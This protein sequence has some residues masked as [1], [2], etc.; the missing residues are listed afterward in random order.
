MRSTGV[1]LLNWGFRTQK[2]PEDLYGMLIEKRRQKWRKL[3]WRFGYD[4]DG[5]R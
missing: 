3:N 2:W 1:T 5:Y 4:D